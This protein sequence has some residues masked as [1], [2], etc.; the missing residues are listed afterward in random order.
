MVMVVHH[1]LVV[2][3]GMAFQQ[4]TMAISNAILAVMSFADMI[5]VDSV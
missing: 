2:A 4:V 5:T 1:V 3:L